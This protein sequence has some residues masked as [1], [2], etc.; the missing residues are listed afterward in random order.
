[1]GQASLR[2][3][4]S[5]CLQPLFP[6]LWSIWGITPTFLL[7]RQKVYTVFPRIDRVRSINFS[8]S[9]LRAIIEG[10]LYFESA[11][12]EQTDA[13]LACVNLWSRLCTHVH[14][15]ILRGVFEGALYLLLTSLP[16]ASGL[17]SQPLTVSAPAAGHTC[18]VLCLPL[19][20]DCCLLWQVPASPRR[21]WWP[22]RG[23]AC[24]EPPWP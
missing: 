16:A 8:L 7:G 23:R 4:V 2:R 9:K 6:P 12:A 17:A 18:V 3:S 11:L 21:G 15:Y 19:P 5:H 14:Y 22:M 24:Q 13:I 10:A 20:K 1:M